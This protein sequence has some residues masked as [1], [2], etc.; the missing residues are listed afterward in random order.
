MS[1]RW[2]WAQVCARRLE[3]H[4]LSAPVPDATPADVVEAMCGAHAQVPS[5]AELSVGLRLTEATRVDVRE[6]LWTECSLVRTFGSRG[7]VHLL[8]SRDLLMWTGALSSLPTAR[9]GLPEDARLTPGQ[10][11]QVVAAIG[12]ALH[13]E[14]LTVDELTAAVVAATGP[15]AGDGVIPA[16]QGIWPRWRQAIGAAANRGVLCFGRNR[17]RTV[18]YTNP[19]AC[20]RPRCRGRA[21][22]LWPISS[23]ATCTRT[24]R[25]RRSTWP[26]GWPSRRGGPRSGSRPSARTWSR[27]R[28]RG[29]RRGSPPA[30]P[31][32]PPRRP[33]RGAAPPVLRTPTPSAATPAG[34]SSP[35]GPP[36]P[37]WRA[38]RAATSRSC[39]STG[40]SPACGTSAAR[41]GASRSRWIRSTPS[42]PPNAAGSTSKVERV[43]TI[44][45]GVPR[46]IVGPGTV[47]APVNR[48][49]RPCVRDRTTGRRR[50]AW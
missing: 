49:L 33:R 22:R 31:S 12:A 39:S 38:A 4:G 47:G 28:S 18:T 11:D 29:A 48:P 23:A 45:Q 26:G 2:S 27:S 41:G 50:D 19:R 44:L 24:A 46:L 10:T 13:G 42:P 3:R 16:W 20:C 15:W 32:P 9:N 7:T 25:P 8:A 36:T 37:R 35:D 40:P 1:T 43:G 5:A 14:E 6:A 30:T 17:G 34:C 21:R